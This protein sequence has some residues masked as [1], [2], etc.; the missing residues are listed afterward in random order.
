MNQMQKVLA[1][2]LLL[3]MV[4]AS[5]AKKQEVI[6]VPEMKG[7]DNPS[8]RFKVMY[9][10]NWAVQSDAKRVSFYSSEDAKSRFIDPTSTGPLGAMITIAFDPQDSLTDISQAVQASKDEIQG[11]RIEPDESV[12]Y[13]ER[14][15]VKYAYSYSVDDKTA[16]YGYKVFALADSTLYSFTAEG[17]NENF[18]AYKAIIDSTFKTVRLMAPRSAATFSSAPSTAMTSLTSDHFDIEYPDNFEASFPKKQKDEIAVAE[19][20]GYRADSKIRVEVN[21]A[22][23]NTLGKVFSTYKS[24]F[25]SSGLFRI[26]RSKEIT[27]GGEKAMYLDLSY[28]KAEVDGRA[29]FA[30]KSDKVYYLFMTWYRPEGNVYLPVFES[31]VKSLKFKG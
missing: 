24:S 19:L 7:Y 9:P 16:L 25:E 18:A 13:S 20:K 31:S 22:K 2:S 5:C 30:V 23:K 8:E 6:P 29:Y 1:L 28:Q 26:G 21:P 11:A 10:G 14:P 17:F 4:L 15:A 3:T 27:I 12:M